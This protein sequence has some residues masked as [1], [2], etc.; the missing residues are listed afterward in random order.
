MTKQ[1]PSWTLG[2]A[3]ATRLTVSREEDGIKSEEKKKKRLFVR[4]RGEKNDRLM[5]R[6]ENSRRRI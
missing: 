6:E 3:I 5:K 2:L 4:N 1:Q